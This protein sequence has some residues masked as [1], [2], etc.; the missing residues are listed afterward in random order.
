MRNLERLR[1]FFS[2]DRAAIAGVASVELAII[3][4]VLVGALI[5]TTDLG[6]GIY[7][8]MQVEA[9]AQA[10]AEYAIARGFTADGVTSAV[11]SAT[12]F[13]SV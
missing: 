4:P 3:A 8:S 11:A 13:G 2:A 6:L 12:S 5:C 10:G 1:R 7:R 9:A